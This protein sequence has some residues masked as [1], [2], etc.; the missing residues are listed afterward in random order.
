ML[1]WQHKRDERLREIRLVAFSWSCA[2]YG[3]LV[4]M[5]FAS[6]GKSAQDL[7]FV[8]PGNGK[9]ATVLF[10]GGRHGGRGGHGGHGRGHHRW[11]KKGHFKLHTKRTAASAG[12]KKAAVEKKIPEKLTTKPIAA[13]PSAPIAD[14]VKKISPK[15]V[16]APA[17]LAEAR[18]KSAQKENVAHKKQPVA[19]PAQQK[20]QGKQEVPDRAKAEKKAQ[21]Q[22]PV[23]R[24]VGADAAVAQVPKEAAK[25]EVVAQRD[26]AQRAKQKPVAAPQKI[27][28]PEPEPEQ[29]AEVVRESE[30]ENTPGEP[31]EQTS[32]SDESAPDQVAA[33][34]ESAD[35]DEGEGDDDEDDIDE[36]DAEGSEEGLSRD[37]VALMRSIGRSW[38]PPRGLKADLSARLMVRLNGDGKVE[39][40]IIDQKSGVLAYDMAARASLWR[41]E[42]PAVFWG[43]TVAI[44]FGSAT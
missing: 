13:K 21:A 23:V 11:H 29:P 42:Y 18:K 28:E 30:P 35:D 20:V 9:G 26:H 31:E 15:K 32:V 27:P 39:D 44:V 7:F 34:D 6:F 1:L 4:W 2:L 19:K 41:A 22:K 17:K 14:E 24:D 36:F 25:K 16:E 5:L 3:A 33:D 40:V 12:L 38:R 43:K 37:G 10:Q 8:L